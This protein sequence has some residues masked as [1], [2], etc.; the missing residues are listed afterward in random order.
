MNLKN[1]K[2]FCDYKGLDIFAGVSVP[3]SLDEDLVKSAIMMRCGLLTPVYNEPETFIEAETVWFES[4]QW[5]FEHLINIIQAEYSPIENVDRYD[6]TSNTHTG[7]D[8]ESGGYSNTESGSD[9]LDMDGTN[10]DEI[11]AFNSSSYQPDNKNTIDR[12]DKTTYGHKLTNSNSKSMTYGSTESFTQHL[13]GNIGV[14]TNQQL[15]N[16]ELDLIKNFHVYDYIAECFEK[17]FMIM[18][19]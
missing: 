19:Y 9:T 3:D 10:T 7:T 14:T 5:M 13:H 6:T 18:V 8:S 11:S 17:E 2:D 16:G 1:F 15:I 4:N 12:T